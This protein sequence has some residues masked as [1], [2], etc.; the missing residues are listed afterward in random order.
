LGRVEGRLRPPEIRDVISGGPSY[1]Y[2][3]CAPIGFP[4][5]EV[6]AASIQVGVNGGHRKILDSE[7]LLNEGAFSRNS[8]ASFYY[9]G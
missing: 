2:G 5:F 8:V 1:T 7:D 6:E 4:V 9:S 3:V